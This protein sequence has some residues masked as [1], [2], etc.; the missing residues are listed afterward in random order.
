MDAPALFPE[1]APRP[2]TR[3]RRCGRWLKTRESRERGIGP[4]CVKHEALKEPKDEK[5]FALGPAGRTGR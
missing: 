1:F 4:E 5:F 3:C 2:G